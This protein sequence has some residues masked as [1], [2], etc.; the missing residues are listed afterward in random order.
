MG[1]PEAPPDYGYAVALMGAGLA[2]I[3]ATAVFLYRSLAGRMDQ[4]IQMHSQ[5][6][7]DEKRRTENAESEAKEERKR[8]DDMQLK[9]LEQWQKAE[10]ARIDARGDVQ[11]SL[12]ETKATIRS[13]VEALFRGMEGQVQR[14]DGRIDELSASID[15]LRNE[16]EAIKKDA[17]SMRREFRR[18]SSQRPQ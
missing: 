17:E 5:R 12:D 11:R 3:A 8:A 4:I 6:L 9:Q 16:I 13:D 7:D 18:K 1:I 14:I 10:Q 15:A 2:A